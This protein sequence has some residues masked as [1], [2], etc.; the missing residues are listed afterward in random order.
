M[1]RVAI[2]WRAVAEAELHP[3]RVAVLELAT[4]REFAPVEVATFLDEPLGTVAYHVRML[5]ERGLLRETRTE[6]RRGAVKHYYAATE[7]A[8]V[9]DEDRAAV[10]A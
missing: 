10:L 6:Q 2:D 7:L 9:Q 1:S 5:V 8:L 3:I 4:I